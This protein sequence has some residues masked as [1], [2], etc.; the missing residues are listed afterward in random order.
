MGIKQRKRR[1]RTVSAAL[2]DKGFKGIGRFLLE[3]SQLQFSIRFVLAARLGLDEKY[4]DIV[5]GPYDFAILCTVTEKASIVKY[6]EKR[7]Q[8]E[9]V[10]KECRKLN[11]SRVL[12]AHAMWTDDFDGL[13]ARHFSRNSLT[14][15]THSFKKDEFD[16]LADKAQE[17]VRRVLNFQGTE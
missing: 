13:S 12:I 5:T 17:L 16:R 3:F 9:K 2:R 1:R 15:A 10:F 7:V 6:P 8:I 4:F 14:T 11:E